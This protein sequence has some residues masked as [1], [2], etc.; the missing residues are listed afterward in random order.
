M[1]E[2]RRDLLTFSVSDTGLR[3]GVFRIEDVTVRPS[4]PEFEAFEQTLFEEIRRET[5]LDDIKNDPVFRSYRDL[6]WNHG[7]DPTKVRVSSEALVRRIVAGQNLWRVNNVVDS[8]NLASA[9]LRV[10]I[11]LIDEQK[12][13]GGLCVRTARPG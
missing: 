5:D 3:V 11:G 4:T 7:L 2:I 10:P 13:D 6:Y 12:I 8:A 9:T 1:S